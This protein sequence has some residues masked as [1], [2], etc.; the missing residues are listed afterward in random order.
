MENMKA[1]NRAVSV[2]TLALT[3]TVVS[4]PAIARLR[5][6]ACRDHRNAF[7][8]EAT[9]AGDAE[10]RMLIRLPRARSMTMAGCGPGCALANEFSFDPKD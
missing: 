5:S 1:D 7:N 4:S 6:R 2:L 9:S 8:A 10:A 3:S